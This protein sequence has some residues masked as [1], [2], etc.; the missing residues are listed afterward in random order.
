MCKINPWRKVH[1]IDQGLL[2]RDRRHM[3]VQ[4][5]GI[6]GQC[7]NVPPP[8]YPPTKN[9]SSIQRMPSCPEKT[10]VP[11][12]SSKSC[13]QGFAIPV[14]LPLHPVLL[15]VAG[16]SA[17]QTAAAGPNCT[18]DNSVPRPKCQSVSDESAEHK[19]I[20]FYCLICVMFSCWLE[21]SEDKIKEFG[22]CLFF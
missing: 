1:L 16:Y 6:A 3:I 12:V 18:L 20:C 22:V 2:H 4:G 14:M 15:Q 19:S 17:T 21:M 5:L 11:V 13:S 10:L 8:Q 7:M 9:G